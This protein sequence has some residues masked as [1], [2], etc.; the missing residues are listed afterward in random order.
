MNNIGE[1]VKKL[2]LID[3]NAIIHRAYHA[4]PK[5]LRTRKGEQTNVVYGFATTLVKVIEDLSPSHFAAT[6]DLADPTFRH[7]LFEEYKATRVKAD[8]EL[9]DQIPRVKQLVETMGIPIYEKEGYEADDVIGTIVSKVS[10][11]TDL[12]HRSKKIGNNQCQSVEKISG[13]VLQIFIVS[14]DKDIFQLINGNVKVYNLKKGLS[15]TQIIDRH[16]IEQ[17]YNLQPEDFIDLKALAGD[18]SDNIPGVP[19][20]GPKTATELIQ[21]FDT[22]AKLYEAIE[23]TRYKIRDTNKNQISNSKSQKDIITTETGIQDNNYKPLVKPEMT[24]EDETNL[25]AKELGL[26][27]RITRLLIDN[28]E[29]AFLS[30]H[31]ATIHCDVPINFDLD[32]CRFG[33][34][35]KDKLKSL[36]KELG[37]QSLIRRYSEKVESGKTKEQESVNY[38]QNVN[39]Q[40]KLL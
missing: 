19:G 38:S 13:G 14:G 27:P 25:V 26:K 2:V 39:D 33:D 32:Q 8:Q 28:K 4:I 37:F 7:E 24:A 30:Q 5:T 15:Q 20:I 10:T 23:D 31:L 1:S 6:F 40:L 21:R 17:E 11:S 34:Y 18:S 36:F 29:Q 3:S 9:Y 35:D 22:L 16:I 12:F